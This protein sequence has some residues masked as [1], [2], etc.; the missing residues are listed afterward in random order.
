MTMGDV[1]M[2]AIY[3]A[4]D[5]AVAARFTLQV[6]PAR[7]YSNADPEG[8]FRRPPTGRSSPPSASDLRARPDPRAAEP[9][10]AF[11]GWRAR[12]DSN[13]QHLA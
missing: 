3:E 11:K 7:Q 2:V 9:E 1:D 10:G 6:G 5:D 4:P 12:Q 8:V 13:L